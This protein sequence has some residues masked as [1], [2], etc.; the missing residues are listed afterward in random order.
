MPDFHKF[1]NSHIQPRSATNG[2]ATSIGVLNPRH[3]L[4]RLF[5]S[6]SIWDICSSLI[7]LKSVPLGKYHLISPFICS[8]VP[9]SHDEYGWA[10]KHLISRLDVISWCWAFSVPLSIVSVLLPSEGNTSK[11]LTTASFL[12]S[13]VLHFIVEPA[14]YHIDQLLDVVFGIFA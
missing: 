8:F 10:K 12:L 9:R 7:L 1:I 3:F 4:G 5:I 13:Q 2:E 6:D 14:H 11:R